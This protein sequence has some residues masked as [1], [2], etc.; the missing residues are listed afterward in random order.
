MSCALAMMQF[1]SIY[2]YIYLVYHYVTSQLYQL[3]V[4][5]YT[6]LCIVCGTYCMWHINKMN[7]H[8]KYHY[9]LRD[10]FIIFAL[11]SFLQEFPVVSLASPV[12]AVWTP[13][14][15]PPLVM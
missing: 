9:C 2:I 10:V 8:N 4:H 5:L 11:S 15:A 1:H 12:M 7:L 13:V 3:H 14:Q 6:Y